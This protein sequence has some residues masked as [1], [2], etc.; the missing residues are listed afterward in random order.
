LQYDRRQGRCA[1]GFSRAVARCPTHGV[2]PSGRGP[3]LRLSRF[4]G[5]AAPLA[6][7][8]DSLRRARRRRQARLR[9][10]RP[11]RRCRNGNRLPFRLGA[12]LRCCQ[13]LPACLRIDS[14]GA[15]CCSPGTFLHFSL[16]GV[17]LNSCYY[18]QDL[19]WPPFHAASRQRFATTAT[20]SYSLLGKQRQSIGS[21]L[22]RH[23]FSGLLHSAGKS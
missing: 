8:D 5:A 21:P 23:P 17:R 14:P 6:R 19:H 2:C 15:N 4:P 18:H 11:A 3:V 13:A 9:C 10:R 12:Q 16:Q 7:S 1:P 20:P 22:Q